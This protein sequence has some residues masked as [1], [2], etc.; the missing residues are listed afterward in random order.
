[1]CV[2]ALVFA[3]LSGLF[4]IGVPLLNNTEGQPRTLHWIMRFLLFFNSI[5][6]F[7]T[8]LEMDRGWVKNTMNRCSGRWASWSTTS[9]WELTMK[10]VRKHWTRWRA[11]LGWGCCPRCC[12][13]KVN[14][15]LARERT[16]FQ[17]GAALEY[18]FVN[19]RPQLCMIHWQ[20]QSPINTQNFKDIYFHGHIM[21]IICHPTI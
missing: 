12:Q 10:K 11:R 3:F 7:L 4:A 13:A 16:T 9:R 21:I 8:K 18:E 20:L 2:S 14:P 1:M 6:G 19:R 17:K 5:S 15:K